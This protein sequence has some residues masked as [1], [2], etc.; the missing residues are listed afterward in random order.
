MRIALIAALGATAAIFVLA[1]TEAQDASGPAATAAAPPAPAPA[2]YAWRV[3]AEEQAPLA[4]TPEICHVLFDG[5]CNLDP[6]IAAAAAGVSAG[7][8]AEARARLEAEEAARRAALP[9]PP[10]I[11]D[12]GG[13][14]ATL[15]PVGAVGGRPS[16]FAARPGDPDAARPAA[17]PAQPPRDAAAPGASRP[18]QDRPSQDLP[19]RD[20]PA[21]AG[22]TPAGASGLGA[23]SGQAAAAAPLP[24]VVNP[25]G[26]PA[27]PMS[28]PVTLTGRTGV[29]EVDALVD[30]LRRAGLADQLSPTVSPDTPGVV[31]VSPGGLAPQPEARPPQARQPAAAA[32][33]PAAPPAAAPARAP[34]AQPA[35]SPSPARSAQPAAPAPERTP[36]APLRLGA[37]AAN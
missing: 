21:Q 14:I 34:Q 9:P 29:E 17:A 25:S 33:R 24:A 32:A 13:L 31:L 11:F 36:G 3:R 15:P 6:S 27:S 5:V 30:A 16:A 10:T 7:Q 18:A 20:R 28:G 12:P 26:P 1:N 22:Q 37:P 4:S 23:A 35:A 2:P 8:E 19:S